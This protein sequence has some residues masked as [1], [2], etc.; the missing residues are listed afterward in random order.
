MLNCFSL[1]A[2][3]I[4]Y[5]WQTGSW[6]SEEARRACMNAFIF[7]Y[8]GTMCIFLLKGAT[9]VLSVKIVQEHYTL[10][11]ALVVLSEIIFWFSMCCALGFLVIVAIA[12]FAA[13]L[14]TQSFVEQAMLFTVGAATPCLERMPLF[15]QVLEQTV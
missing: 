7:T 12:P 6:L 8:C 11:L 13:D 3:L 2:G 10:S 14:A 9:W 5:C 1:H 15:V 4:M